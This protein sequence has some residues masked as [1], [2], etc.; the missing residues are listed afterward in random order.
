MSRSSKKKESPESLPK[1]VGLFATTLVGVGVILGSGI[2][3]LV[4][5]AARTAGNAVW[6]SFLIAAVAAALT[7][8]SYARLV[9]YEPKDAPEFHYVTRAFG[10]FPGFVAGWFMVWAGIISAAAVSLG[11]ASYLNNLFSIPLIVSASGLVAFCT[12]VAFLGITQSTTL[13][14]I[15]TFVEAAGLLIVIITGAPYFGKVNY[16]ETPAGVPGLLSTAALVFFAYLGFEGIVNLAEEMRNPKRDLPLA[17]LLS[18]AISSILYVLVSVAA[19]SVLGWADLSASDAP[20]AA[21]VG[22]VFGDN[23]NLLLTGIALGS[24][25]NTTLVL[26]VAVSRALWGMSCAGALPTN[27]CVLGDK[28]QTPWMAILAVGIL[29][30]LFT[31][32]GE[33]S[34]V[35][36]LSNFATLVAFVGVNASAFKILGR[37][38]KGKFRRFFLGYFLPAAGVIV[39][40]VLIYFTGAQA[41]LM[42][43]VVLVIGAGVYFLLGAV[44]K[45]KRSR[46]A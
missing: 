24:T 2:Y 12:F 3:V 28:R 17:I 35:A 29:T 14:S 27:F 22:R 19:V 37:E 45:R 25:A 15:L 26:L 10:R 8:I 20:L 38:T 39:S 5:V 13:A 9:R 44:Q 34:A 16:L 41:A 11:F 4:G 46:N 23:A 30:A 1:H 36:E 6:I 32:I 31:T 18:I 33:I 7:G 42:G 40:L 43:G 21:V